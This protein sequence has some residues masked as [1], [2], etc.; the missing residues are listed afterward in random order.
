L[1]QAVVMLGSNVIKSIVLAVSTKALYKY[2]GIT[3]H[4]MWDHSIGAAIAARLIAAEHGRDLAEVAFIGGLMHDVGKVVMSNEAHDAFV[5]V[6]RKTYNDGVDSIDA[7]EAVFS[8]NH[9]EIGSKVIAKWG[10]PPNLVQILARHH[11]DRCSLEDIA[12]PFVAK[13]TACVCLAD[14]ICKLLG[15]GYRSPD[16][17]IVIHEHPSVAFL[18]ISKDEVDKLIEETG[19]AYEEEKALFQ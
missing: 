7:E 6:M 13:A 11:L 14:S 19:T 9:I 15:I 12:D 1:N 3:E 18:H 10:F 16:D 8:Y 2:A 17:T 4:M 5:E